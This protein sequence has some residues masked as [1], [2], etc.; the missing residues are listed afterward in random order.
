MVR[1]VFS[2]NDGHYAGFTVKGHA[3]PP[4][5]DSEYDLVCAAVSSTVYLTCN[6]LTDFVG[7]CTATQDENEI[8]LRVKQDS[9]PVQA[10]LRSFY[11][12][13][14]DIARQYPRNI[15]IIIGGESSC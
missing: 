14:R 12:H 13:M 9:E 10:I 6:T 4:E 2:R 8:T 7:G 3:M 1:A 15:N 11:E 5:R